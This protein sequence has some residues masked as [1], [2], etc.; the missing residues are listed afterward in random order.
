ML[1]YAV[2]CYNKLV[3]A[4]LYYTVLYTYITVM[5]YVI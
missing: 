3:C 4:M 2:I 1:A 5:C